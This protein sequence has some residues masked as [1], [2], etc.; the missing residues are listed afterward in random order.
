MALLTVHGK[1]NTS[2]LWPTGSASA[3]TLAIQVDA[4]QVDGRVTHVLEGAVVV[5]DGAARPALRGSQ[6]IVRLQGADAPELCYR[7]GGPSAGFRQSLAGT[8]AQAL[9]AHLQR[10]GDTLLTCRALTEVRGPQD[11]LDRH[12][13]LV[14]DLLV[15]SQSLGHWLL[16][17]GLAFPALYDSMSR[18]ELRRVLAASRSAHASHLPVWRQYT[19][20]LGFDPRAVFRPR[21]QPGDDDARLVLP[22]LFRRLARCYATRGSVERFR[23]FLLAGGDLVHRLGELQNGATPTPQ[24]LAAYVSITSRA[25]HLDLGPEELVF[26]E[27]PAELRGP[28]GG[29]ITSW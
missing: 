27:A 5:A 1:L 4:I 10:G 3:D 21:P 17:Q 7:G 13:R 16:E 8:A 6:L 2:Q 24:P 23:D 20:E 29:L 22:K 12:G 28:D 9:A 18:P 25:R 15:G 26:K 19:P 14:G 11:L